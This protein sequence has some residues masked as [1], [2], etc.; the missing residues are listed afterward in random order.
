MARHKNTKGEPQMPIVL[1][2]KGWK[3]V[4]PTLKEL[5]NLVK[6]GKEEI[7]KQAALQS[8]GR[9]DFLEKLDK[10]NFFTS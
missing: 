8:L 9:I 2:E 7:V 6:L 10:E 3:V 5:S 4:E 1:T